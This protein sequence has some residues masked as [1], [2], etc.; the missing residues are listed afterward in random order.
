MNP[1]GWRDKLRVWM[2]QAPE[3]ALD[4][5]SRFAPGRLGGL[6]YRLYVPPEALA[7]SPLV[8][9]LHGAGGAGTDNRQ[10]LQR[11]SGYVL[12][13]ILEHEPAAHVLA[14]QW[15]SSSSRGLSGRG[16]DCFT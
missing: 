9:Y 13:R 14:S 1:R 10:Q 5:R 7:P 8:V 4:L 2:G 6:V 3:Q 12:S 15:P 11:G 16:W